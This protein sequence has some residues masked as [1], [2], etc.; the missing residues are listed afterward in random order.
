M[1]QTFSSLDVALV[2]VKRASSSLRDALGAAGVQNTDSLPTVVGKLYDNVF[3]AAAGKTPKLEIN[4]NGF[5][6]QTS[7]GLQLFVSVEDDGYFVSVVHPRGWYRNSTLLAS[8]WLEGFRMDEKALES[9]GF[10]YNDETA[11]AVDFVSRCPIWDDEYR[12]KLIEQVE[13]DLREQSARER[14]AFDAAFGDDYEGD[15]DEYTPA[16]AAET[17][18]KLRNSK[19]FEEDE[20]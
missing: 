6:Y 11:K 8:L 5:A 10:G 4:E 15:E 16:L 7:G 18:A 20:V 2:S 3:N 9:W 19:L 12:A 14:Q 13:R 17:I 1:Y